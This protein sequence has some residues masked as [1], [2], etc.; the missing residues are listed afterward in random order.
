MLGESTIAYFLPSETGEKSTEQ[1]AL[2]CLEERS[3][4]QCCLA[5]VGICKMRRSFRMPG[6]VC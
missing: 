1:F 5:T 2:L 3:N 4:L 6:N